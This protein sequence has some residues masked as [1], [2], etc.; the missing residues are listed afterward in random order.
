MDAIIDGMLNNEQRKYVFFQLVC[1]VHE[2]HKAGLVHQTLHRFCVDPHLIVVGN[3]CK[4]GLIDL[5]GVTVQTKDDFAYQWMPTPRRHSEGGISSPRSPPDQKQTSIFDSPKSARMTK[6]P[7]TPRRSLGNMNSSLNFSPRKTYSRDYVFASQNERVFR[8]V[9]GGDNSGQVNN[10][11]TLGTIFAFLLRGIP[12]FKG[13]T[14][15][16]VW[17]RVINLFGRPTPSDWSSRQHNVKVFVEQLI[18]EKGFDISQDRHLDY[19]FGTCTKDEIDLLRG[20][21]CIN[22]E[23][24]LTTEQILQHPYF[25]EFRQYIPKGSLFNKFSQSLDED[26]S[27][28]DTT[29]VVAGSNFNH[30]TGML[31]CQ[32]H[33]TLGFLDDIN[34]VFEKVPSIAKVCCTSSTTMLLAKDGRVFI[35]GGS[36]KSSLTELDLDNVVDIDCNGSDDECH[37][38]M[39]RGDGKLFVYG[40][41]NHGQLSLGHTSSISLIAPVKW[42][43]NESPVSKIAAGGKHTIVTHKGDLYACGANEHKQ[44]GIDDH[45]EIIP[46]LTKV[47]TFTDEVLKDVKCGDSHTILLTESG[48]VFTFGDNRFGQ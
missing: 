6:S 32:L 19:V 20:M 40:S 1:A 37:Y 27:E 31:H 28:C 7:R 35:L 43:E 13:S 24:R 21:L 15:T 22:Q 44:C 41:N 39:L 36:S 45:R 8:D 18:Q 16:E 17:E 5:T 2:L 38:L 14:S 10:I 34:S 9:T 26:D 4:V 3:G 46:L 48:R 25:D 30:Q 12:I 47:A 23:N 33:P 42:E 11:W 29:L